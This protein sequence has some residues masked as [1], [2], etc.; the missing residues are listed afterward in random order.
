MELH[1][2]EIFVDVMSKGSFA[3]V[4]RDRNVPPSSIS[5]AIANLEEQLG[6]RLFH[7][8]TR[9]IS[10]TEAGHTYFTRISPLIDDLR[11]ASET[12]HDR[13][14][15]LQGTI[16]MT[17]SVSFGQKVIIPVLHQFM[18]EHPSITLDFVLTDRT[19]DIIGERIDIAVRHGALNDSSLIASKLKSTYYRVVVSPSYLKKYGTPQ[20]P[21]D[22]TN[23][24]ALVFDIP[25]FRSKWVFHSAEQES[26]DVP[27]KCRYIVSNAL[28]LRELALNG[29]GISLLADW[30][31]DEDIHSGKLI[32]LFP[33]YTVSAGNYD[34][35]IH[36]IT[37]NRSYMPLKI[38][39]LLDF[40][41]TT[42]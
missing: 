13:E 8:S 10:V 25:Q 23:H 37:P 3:E 4:A 29:A 19:V 27:L 28:S 17:S 39:Y 12:V 20:E 16:R 14:Q 18:E 41:K 6:I 34:T 40:L 21:K 24:S 32:E 1:T 42:I 30:L 26:V 35:S 36:L 9:K 5:R 7:R 11:L 22:L 31:I 15:S 38:R 2:L 33:E